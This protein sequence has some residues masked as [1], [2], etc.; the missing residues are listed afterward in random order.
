MLPNSLNLYPR[1]PVVRLVIFF[2][3]LMSCLAETLFARPTT[4]TDCRNACPFYSSH[5]NIVNI[6][7]SQKYWSLTLIRSKFFDVPNF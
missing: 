4:P 5:E 6:H 7:W 2:P 3:L 1:A